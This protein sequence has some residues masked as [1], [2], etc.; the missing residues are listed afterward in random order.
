MHGWS[1]D[2]GQDGEIRIAG[3]NVADSVGQGEDS[4][5]SF[6]GLIAQ[7]GVVISLDQ[8]G[9]LAAFGDF[10]IVGD[11]VVSAQINTGQD[12]ELETLLSVTMP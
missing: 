12:Q 11:I 1:F 2:L 4:G 7:N 8:D 9:R 5:R 3:A 6:R 10:V